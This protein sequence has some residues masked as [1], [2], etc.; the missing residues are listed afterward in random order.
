MFDAL[1][2]A[3]GLDAGRW[4]VK[5]TIPVICCCFLVASDIEFDAARVL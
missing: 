3:A 5:V 4:G 2:V 1:S